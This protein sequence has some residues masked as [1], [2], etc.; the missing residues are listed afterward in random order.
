MKWARM[1]EKRE[2]EQCYK[3]KKYYDMDDIDMVDGKMLC[4]KCEYLDNLK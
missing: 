2:K 4:N 1:K 3:C